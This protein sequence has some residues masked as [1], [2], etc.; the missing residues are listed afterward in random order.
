MPRTVAELS[1]ED[2][3]TLIG[4][5]IGEKLRELMAD[6]DHGLELHDEV[7]V[8]L[9]EGKERV[10]AGDRGLDFEKALGQLGIA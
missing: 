3:R 9:R 8:R 4:E 6:P 1:V 2:L 5:I 10:A 7:L